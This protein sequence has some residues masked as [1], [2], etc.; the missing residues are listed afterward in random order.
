LYKSKAPEK[1]RQWRQWAFVK[2][3]QALL[4]VSAVGDETEAI[5]IPDVEKMVS[6]FHIIEPAVPFP[7]FE[8]K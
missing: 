4:I 2:N 3:G 5:L 7:G 6:S 1:G 8:G